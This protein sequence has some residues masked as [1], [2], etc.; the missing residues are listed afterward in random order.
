MLACYYEQLRLRKKVGDDFR[1]AKGYKFLADY[2]FEKCHDPQ[3]AETFYRKGVDIAL[4]SG[5]GA[6]EMI[7]MH[8][9]TLMRFYQ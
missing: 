4:S 3:K 2:L 9:Y 5:K 7:E 8:T 6:E 1:L